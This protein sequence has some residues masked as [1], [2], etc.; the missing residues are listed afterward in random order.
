MRWVYGGEY[1]E[2]IVA[3]G[4]NVWIHDE[5]LEQV[6]IITFLLMVIGLVYPITALV[7]SGIHFFCRWIF[8]FGYEASLT[9]V[10]VPLI[11]SHRRLIRR[12]GTRI[13]SER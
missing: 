10:L 12:L 3:D 8:V 11:S 1:P 5:I 13:S 2:T 4:K 6:T 7:F 9:F